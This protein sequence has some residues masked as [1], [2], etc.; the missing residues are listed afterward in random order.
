MLIGQTIHAAMRFRHCAIETLAQAKKIM[1]SSLR[2]PVL[3][4]AILETAASGAFFECHA[5]AKPQGEGHDNYTGSDALTSS[6]FWNAQDIQ[7]HDVVI[8]RLDRH[9]AK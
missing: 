8:G 4:G 3:G 7:Q 6:W 9:G 5:V 2:F 1:V